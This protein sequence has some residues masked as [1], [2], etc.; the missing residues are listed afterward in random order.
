M[1]VPYGS[2]A[3][4]PHHFAHTTTTSRPLTS[5]FLKETVPMRTLIALT[6]L[7]LTSVPAQA[8]QPD[9]PV[10]S[11]S[12]EVVE[13]VERFQT[14]LA[15]RD[16]ATVDELLL[17]DALILEGGGRETK[18]EYFGHHFGADASFLNKMNREVEN[19]QVRVEDG[20][21]WASTKSRLH[22]TYDG[23]SLDLSS[24]ELM[25][26]RHMSEGWR[27]AAI[28]WSSRSRD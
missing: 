2:W 24:A 19:R 22:G 21:A 27:I 1:T 26:L 11:D 9:S 16:S 12:A 7:L 15:E 13:T 17:S 18:M 28:H 5:H 20:T 14:A 3:P 6:V 4:W 25:V 10:H 8:Q 23:D